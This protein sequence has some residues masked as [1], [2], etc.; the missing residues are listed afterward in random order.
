M[1]RRDGVSGPT[2]L[3]QLERQF[4]KQP[5]ARARLNYKVHLLHKATPSR[6]GKIA[7][8]PNIN[9]HRESSKTRKERNMFQMKEQGKTP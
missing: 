4:K 7:V 2:G 5:K 1:A 8:M 9:K 3:K 6:L